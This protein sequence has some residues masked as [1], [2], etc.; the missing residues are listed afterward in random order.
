MMYGLTPFGRNFD[1]FNIFNDMDKV[2]F[3]G[4][5]PMNSC[6]TDIKD[7]G[8]K[9][10]M[11]SELPG[12][13]KDDIKLDLNGSCLVISAEHKTENSEKDDKGNYIR[14]ERSYGSY[15]RSF[16]IPDVDVE[17]I[18]AE[19]KNGILTIDLPKKQPESPIAKRLEIK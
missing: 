1:L 2:Y 6:R 19:Y 9:Y 4:A 8:D 3:G 17:K 7:E 18:N 5:M 11:E 13:E 14:R 16:D 10:V 15:K 12:F